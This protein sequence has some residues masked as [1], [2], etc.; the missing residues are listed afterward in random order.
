MLRRFTP[1][2]EKL[3]IIMPRVG[4]NNAYV[5]P[6]FYPH[7]VVPTF[8]TTEQFALI[9]LPPDPGTIG[10]HEIVH[11]IQR[12]QVD[13]IPRVVQHI[14]G[15]TTYNPQVG[16]DS[17]FWEGLAVYYETKLQGGIG[18][19][20]SPYFRGVFGAGVAGK[21]LSGGYLQAMKRTVPLGPQYLIGSH[22][23]DWLART[24][25]E[26]KL[27]QLVAHQ[28]D[29]LLPPLG[30]NTRFGSVYGRS[31]SKL[32]DDF[33][34]HLKR[35]WPVRKRPVAERKLEQ[36][37]VYARYTR[38][39]T[40]REAWISS[41]LDL[42]VRLTVR[43]S[44]GAEL[45]S[46]NLNEIL[47]F[48]KLVQPSVNSVSGLSFTAD[49]RFLYFVMVDQGHTFP[50]TR[51]M[52]LDVHEDALEQVHANING[53]GGS[54]SPDN[55]RYYF[56]QANDDH[57]D[58][59]F[60]DLKSAK[61]QRLQTS[62]PGMYVIAPRVSP[63]GSRLVA[64]TSYQGRIQLELFDA[65]TGAKLT[66]PAAPT[67]DHLLASWVDAQHLVYAGEHQGRFQIYQTDLQNGSYKLLTDAPHFAFEPYSDGTHLRFLN[68]DGWRWTLDEVRLSEQPASAQPNIA[69][70]LSH[71]EE[72]AQAPLSTTLEVE[73][74]EPYSSLDRL[75]MPEF[76]GPFSLY[77]PRVSSV[78]G[79][80]LTGSDMLGYHRWTILG[81]YDFEVDA[82][83]ASISY[84]N[85]QLA[86]YWIDA[87]ASYVT[88][89]NSVRFSD[90]SESDVTERNSFGQLLLTRVFWG[91][92]G[93]SLGV[94][95][96]QFKRDTDAPI[97]TS[98]RR[99]VGPLLSMSYTG[100]E[101]TAYTGARRALA[102]Q[103]SAAH[104]PTA[105]STLDDGL[106]DLSANATLVVPLPLWRR[107]TLNVSGRGRSLLG[108]PEADRLLQVGGIA[109]GY[110]VAGET[111]GI[112]SDD[113]LLPPSVR[114]IE[115]VRGYE[116]LAFFAHRYV[117][118]ELVYR[119]PLIV[120]AGTASSL[121]IFPSV[122]LRQFDFELFGVA[123]SLLEAGDTRL[124]AAGAALVVRLNLWVYPFDLVGQVA[125]RFEQDNAWNGLLFLRLLGG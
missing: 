19:L 1:Y 89:L 58:L 64:A 124:L 61:V 115:S 74:D 98:A 29:E 107:H 53:A 123:G 59:A 81:A 54:I 38:A 67:G 15:H 31:L 55:K 60:F 4:M 45:M 27:W 122:F 3:N 80:A 42:P 125:R 12:L 63:D 83:S 82:P 76:W 79:L 36:L 111:F 7:S 18:R 57:Y 46:R 96:T 88:N 22:F 78:L 23:I 33:N 66:K 17:W 116:N 20:G 113:G 92:N 11:Y 93:V 44:D 95:G 87:N 30:V 41:D 119:A 47:P 69:R 8:N 117:G 2:Y 10:C 72:T 13:G 26:H 43:D 90:G 14:F 109:L 101:R 68:R 97:D 118:G 121:G 5:M 9:G 62:A 16:L 40:G 70:P 21:D 71:A 52:R 49:G 6:V 94:T 32:I 35:E 65:R 73:S 105:L 50:I 37:G 108:G 102:A 100:V 104:Y 34:A 99:L 24:Y 85:R 39:A 110:P 51:L 103:V 25:G 106:S 114:F 77:I 112:R 56:V 91:S 120:D 28:S 75:F 48:R 84:S 86:P